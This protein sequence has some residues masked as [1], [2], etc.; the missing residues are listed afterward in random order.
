MIHRLVANAL[1]AIFSK[2]DAIAIDMPMTVNAV[3]IYLAIILAGCVVVS[4]ADS[5]AAKEIAT[6]LRVSKA[7]GIFTQV[8]MH[9]HK[10]PVTLENESS[11]PH[12]LLPPFPQPNELKEGDSFMLT[13]EDMQSDNKCTKITNWNEYCCVLNCVLCLVNPINE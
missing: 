3:I 6:R 5:F 1:D 10:S 7:K 13:A 9:F 12:V 8:I 4:I 2:G 11:W